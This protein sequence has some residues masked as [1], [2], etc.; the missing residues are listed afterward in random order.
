MMFLPESATC[1]HTRLIGEEACSE[2]HTNSSGATW[3][4]TCVFHFEARFNWM[5]FDIMQLNYHL[6][7]LKCFKH[8]VFLLKTG[9]QIERITKSIWNV[10]FF[11]FVRAAGDRRAFRSSDWHLLLPNKFLSAVALSPLSLSLERRGKKMWFCG[12]YA[13][14]SLTCPSKTKLGNWESNH[15]RTMGRKDPRSL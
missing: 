9:L 2:V 7:W 1:M 3:N 15:S 8:D 12:D 4:R 6:D 10:F 5:K 13:G 11:S 14:T